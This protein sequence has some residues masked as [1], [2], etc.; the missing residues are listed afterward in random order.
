MRAKRIRGAY[1]T[2]AIVTFALS[3]VADHAPFIATSGF[4]L[5]VSMLGVFIATRQ[6][7]QES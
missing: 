5:V 6:E 7:R 4:N 1:V 2:M 3:L